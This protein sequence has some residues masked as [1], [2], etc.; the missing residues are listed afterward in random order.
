MISEITEDSFES[1]V[2]KAKPYVLLWLFARWC[3]PCEEVTPILE[4][5]AEEYD[6]EEIT[7]LKLDI[8]KS[9]ELAASLGIRGIPAMLLFKGG[10]AP[11]RMIGMFTRAQLVVFLNNN[12]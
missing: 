1:Q 11:A 10:T 6:A 7:F 5:L 12:T 9:P 3:K 2:L 4:K 8:D